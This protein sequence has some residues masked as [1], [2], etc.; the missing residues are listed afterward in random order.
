LSTIRKIDFNL[1]ILPWYTIQTKRNSSVAAM[2][3]D[4]QK[5]KSTEAMVNK[6][7]GEAAGT[8]IIL[9]SSNLLEKQAC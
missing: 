5:K 8:S 6:L 1:L 9:V 3:H 4:L 2:I 7:K